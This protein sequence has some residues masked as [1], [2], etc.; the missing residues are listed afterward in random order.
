[1]VNGGLL[2]GSAESGGFWLWQILSKEE[3]EAGNFIQR[4][5]RV[6][7]ATPFI[8]SPENEVLACPFALPMAA[9]SVQYRHPTKGDEASDEE[10]PDLADW[11]LISPNG[12]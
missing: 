10:L 7:S 4:D 5:S 2:A 3:L 8:V 9:R 6:V 1:M 11:E 12:C